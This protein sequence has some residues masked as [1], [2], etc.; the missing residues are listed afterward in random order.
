MRVDRI[1]I[2]DL[3]TRCIIGIDEQERREKQDVLISMILFTDLRAAGRSDRLEDAID[4][5]AVKKRV[6]A[7]TEHSAF[8]LIEALAERIAE[9]CLEPA[10]V[11]QVQ[12]T[13]E[14]PGALRFARCVGVV[15]ER[16]RTDANHTVTNE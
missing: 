10:A 14:K 2:T 5:R 4:Y 16:N 9:L 8:N 6:L 12:V 3:L 7:M 11:M 13:V 15:I 1:V